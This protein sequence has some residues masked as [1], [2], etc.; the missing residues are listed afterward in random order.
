[1]KKDQALKVNK[2]KPLMSF[3]SKIITVFSP[4]LVCFYALLIVLI[5]DD[6]S[7]SSLAGFTVCL[8]Q[9]ILI[10]ALIILCFFRKDKGTSLFLKR[11]QDRFKAY[12]LLASCCVLGYF[13]GYLFNFSS[14]NLI[15]KI[16]LVLFTLHAMMSLYYQGLPHVSGLAAILE[17]V[18]FYL[19]T[20]KLTIVLSISLILLCWSK[21]YLNMGS[22]RQ[23][24][25]NLA[26]GIVSTSTAFALSL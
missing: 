17:L 21:Y 6:F 7:E 10:P 18:Y 23:I 8:L 4:F 14:Y 20:S 2:N 22:V 15:L 16:G 5:Y 9:I 1:M 19:P 24:V 13:W 12:V 3:A 25:V 26:L 11:Y